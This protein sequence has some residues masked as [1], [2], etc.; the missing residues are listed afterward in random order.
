MPAGSSRPVVAAKHEKHQSD[1]RSERT[2][3]LLVVHAVIGFVFG[4]AHGFVGGIEL[5]THDSAPFGELIDSWH[6]PA[7]P[8]TEHVWPD[9]VHWLVFCVACRR[10]RATRAD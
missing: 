7:T 3:P 4:V 6:V 2:W 9:A 1:A 5:A 10:A 8:L